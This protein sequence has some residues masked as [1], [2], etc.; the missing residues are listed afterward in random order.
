VSPEVVGAPDGLASTDEI[1]GRDQGPLDLA[2]LVA[3]WPA[4]VAH[5]SQKPAIKQLIVTCRPV[6]IDG[7]V[8]NLGFPEEQAFLRDVAER[9]KS[10]IE[11]G[12][13]EVVGRAV[14]VRCVVANVESPAAAVTA[15]DG[16]LLSEAKRIFGDDLVEVA[17]IE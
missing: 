2:G 11:M 8:V 4:V 13:A 16:F 10:A 5:L 9:K 7:S 14:A 3:A 1:Q 15:D 6:S 12:I 17:E